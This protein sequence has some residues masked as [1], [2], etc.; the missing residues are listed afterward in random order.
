MLHR[1][2]HRPGHKH[3]HEGMGVAVDLGPMEDPGVSR[4]QYKA[5]FVSPD[6]PYRNML[7]PKLAEV[8]DSSSNR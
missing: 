3:A 1:H 8:T 5:W 6:S 4:S 2:V 7:D